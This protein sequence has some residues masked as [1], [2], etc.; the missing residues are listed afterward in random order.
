MQLIL[1]GVRSGCQFRIF[2]RF[3]I[4]S[5]QIL[6]KNLVVRC[7]KVILSV[8]YGRVETRYQFVEHL[9]H[10]CHQLL[11]GK[12]GTI[13]AKSVQRVESKCQTLQLYIFGCHSY[14]N[15]RN[16]EAYASVISH[17]QLCA[18]LLNSAV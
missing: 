12:V 5:E 1:L 17:V 11:A 14:F 9:V 16:I 7:M 18:K 13:G 4:Q 10:P 15:V 6:K 3:R 8:Y 2:Q